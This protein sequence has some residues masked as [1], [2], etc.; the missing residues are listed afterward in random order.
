MAHSGQGH[1]SLSCCRP[2]E[3]NS[4]ILSNASNVPVAGHAHSLLND[5]KNKRP[6][7]KE[8]HRPLVFVAHSLGGL[9]IKQALVEAKINE[10]KYGCLKASTYGLVFFATPHAG[11]KKYVLCESLLCS[12]NNPQSIASDWPYLLSGSGCADT[13]NYNRAGIADISS[14]VCSVLTGEPS[15][16]LLA[17]LEK[18]S[19]L[20][21]ISSDQFNHQ[22]SNYESGRDI[23]AGAR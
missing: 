10:Q 1:F 15:N 6:G 18:D 16:S 2:H 23:F 17:T 3:Y 4:S 8:I 21:E 14:K 12:L 5:V 22:M 20:N 9:L 19:L 13:E 7:A 11:G